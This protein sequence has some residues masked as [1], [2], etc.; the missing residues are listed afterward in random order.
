MQNPQWAVMENH[1][2]EIMPANQREGWVVLKERASLA[3][4]TALMGDL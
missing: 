3:V 2:H 1:S 4:V